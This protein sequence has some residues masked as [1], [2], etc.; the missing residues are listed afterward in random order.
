MVLIGSASLKAL[1]PVMMDHCRTQ[2]EA[3]TGKKITMLPLSNPP[4]AGALIWAAELAF[5]VEYT[6]SIRAKIIDATKK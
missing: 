3:Y 4:A 5:G 1:S 2:I 6:D